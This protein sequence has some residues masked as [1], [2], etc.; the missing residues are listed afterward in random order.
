MTRPY[1]AWRY[2]ETE[3]PRI[4]E[5][6]AAADALDDGW[7]D[8]PAK[9]PGFLNRVGIPTPTPLEVQ[10]TG[11]LVEVGVELSNLVANIEKGAK[12]DI[13]RL[14]ELTWG[15]DWSTGPNSKLK[16]ADLRTAVQMRLQAEPPKDES[17]PA[18]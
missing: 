5:D 2:H 11:E 15:E 8:S 3:A 10:A 14:V 16:V 13:Y 18:S 4:F 9:V 7:Y 1:R 17:S 12:K 6:Q